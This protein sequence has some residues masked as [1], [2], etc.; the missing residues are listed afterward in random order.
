VAAF[1]V[2]KGSGRGA[3]TIEHSRLASA[4]DVESMRAFWRD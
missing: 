4:D 1:F 3:L 2:A